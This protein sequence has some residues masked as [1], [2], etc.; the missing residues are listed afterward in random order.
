MRRVLTWKEY[1]A[2]F[3]SGVQCIFV[4]DKDDEWPDK[5]FIYREDEG[6]SDEW[7]REQFSDNPTSYVIDV[8]G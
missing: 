8:E 4:L 7:L 6:C 2:L 1:H 5:N 3:R